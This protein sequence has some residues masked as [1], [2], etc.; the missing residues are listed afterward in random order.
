MH[1]LCCTLI[2]LLASLGCFVGSRYFWTFLMNFATQYH[3]ELCQLDQGP[4][5]IRNVC[6]N[7]KYIGCN[8]R[9]WLPILPFTLIM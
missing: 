9:R 8:S 7:K 6:F 2:N 3:L 1:N 5:Y 4:S